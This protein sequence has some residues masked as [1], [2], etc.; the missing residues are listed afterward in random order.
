M[1][2]LEDDSEWANRNARRCKENAALATK[3]NL[4]RALLT[5]KKCKLCTSELDLNAAILRNPKPPQIRRRFV[6]LTN[7][8]N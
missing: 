5:S 6:T 4:R 3:R 8:M 2:G 1:L 7:K